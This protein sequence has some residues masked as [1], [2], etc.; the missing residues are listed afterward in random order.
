MILFESARV[1]LRKMTKDDTVLY[2]TWRNDQEIMRSTNPSL[3][4]Y[5]P[6]DTQAFVEHVILGSASSKSYILLEKENETPIGVLGLINIDY[7]N[8]NAECIIDIG[9]KKYWGQGYGSEGMK[10]LL[11]YCFNEMNMHRLSLRV[12]SF[13]ERAIRLYKSLGFQQEGL[14]KEALFREGKWHDIVHMGLLQR[15]YIEMQQR[16]E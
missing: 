12:F 8:Q 1:K 15:D 10:L 7:K 5:S 11:G 2:H 9:E 6:Q 14:S 4:V 3:D 16:L 13:N